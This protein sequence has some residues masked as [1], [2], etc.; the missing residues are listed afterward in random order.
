MSADK[1][2]PPPSANALE[3]LPRSFCPS[4]LFSP[5]KP[6]LRVSNRVFHAPASSGDSSFASA[7]RSASHLWDSSS[8]L[9]VSAER[10]VYPCKA[11]YSVCQFSGVAAGRDF[12]PSLTSFNAFLAFVPS[13]LSSV[14]TSAFAFAAVCSI[15]VIFDAAFSSTALN[16]SKIV[17][18]GGVVSFPRKSARPDVAGSTTSSR[19]LP[20]DVLIVSSAVSNRRCALAKPSL[21]RAKSPC[22]SAVACIRY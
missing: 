21:V 3:I 7:A 13:S 5:G 6:S 2:A 20:T 17:C 1:A 16:E 4:S 9:P 19:K 11:L 14:S 22:A 10:L 12:A 15:C 8:L 18:S